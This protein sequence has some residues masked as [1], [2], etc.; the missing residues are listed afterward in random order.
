MDSRYERQIA[1]PEIGEKGQR[2]LSA[3][4]VVVVGA[5]GLGSPVL[6]CLASAGVGH[7]KIIDSDRLDITNLNR[8]FLHFE[9]DIGRQKALSA[10]EKL[11]RYNPDIYVHSVAVALDSANTTKQLSGY[12]I[13]LSCVDN[14]KARYLLNRA[15]VN[16]GIPLVD[17][18]LRG[19]EGYVLTVL[20]GV[21]PCYH[22]LFPQKKGKDP[23]GIPG[24]LG[25][26]AGVI[27]S[28]MAVEAVKHIAGIPI[29]SY[30]HYVDTLSFRVTPIA[31]KRRPD[32]LVCGLGSNALDTP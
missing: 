5:G 26:V 8:Q 4:R 6:Y 3:A 12:D 11:A 9:S 16:G 17:G 25:A 22:C 23:S 31:A 14:K 18:G 15:C 30:F 1:L 19:F 2:K 32:C 7:I 13:V 28:M 10:Q 29:D 20:P 24:V 27:G 21:T